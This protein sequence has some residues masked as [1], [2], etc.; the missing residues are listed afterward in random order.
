M[1]EVAT[2]LFLSPP[3]VFPLV[4]PPPPPLSESHRGQYKYTSQLLALEACAD[5]RGEL[6]AYLCKIVTPLK[7]D[8]WQEALED[9]PDQAFANYILG[10]IRNGFRIGFNRSRVC[11]KS[12]GTNMLSATE[13]SQVVAKYL[14]EELQA[15]R[16]VE[17]RRQ[18]Q[19][20]PRIQF[21]P[22][23]VIPKT[24]R[25][26]KW[27][28]IIDLS[29][30]DGHSVNDGIS[31]ELASL[32]YM[33]VDDVVRGL[34]QRGRGALLAKMDIKQAYRNIPVH[35][36]DRLL[37]GMR[38]EES[39]FVDAALPFGLRSAPLIF[40]AVGDALQWVMESMGA[41]W[42]AHYIDDFVTIGAPDSPECSDN[43][44]IMQAE[45]E[46]VGFPVEPEKSGGPA[47]TI[48]FLGVELDSRMLEIRLPKEKLDRLRAE[49]KEWRGRKACR[50]R[51]LLS[52][53]GS[54]SHACKAVRAGRSFLRRL[55]DLSTVVEKLDHYVR[56]SREARADIELW[57]QYAE[58]WNGTS[59][60]QSVQEAPPAA[61]VTSD[62]SE[63]WQS[64]AQSK[65]PLW[66]SYHSVIGVELVG[67][68]SPCGV[69]IM[70]T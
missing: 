30:P 36:Q 59:M 13:Q 68:N 5:G 34:L 61:V 20:L 9:H 58:A 21:S 29:S 48:S 32:T 35:P 26:G 28:L 54:L 11:L 23:G 63:N 53:I 45:C 14:G 37:L 16:I 44:Q 40:S 52:L 6:P 50:K 27:R 3:F 1:H 51:E 62:A 10:G 24:N 18:E 43:A 70:L 22:F 33:S 66:G 19:G 4:P 47:T 15:S 42:V 46:R 67:W 39:I 7:L 69:I 41:K 49:L 55:I 65:A 64:K 56:L 2:P 31:K 25:P 8:A 57:V 60:M 17:I 38:W 12:R